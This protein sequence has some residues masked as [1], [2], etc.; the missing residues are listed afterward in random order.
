MENTGP[1]R[2][3]IAD[4]EERFRTTTEA[5]LKKRGFS[6]IVAAGGFQAIEE[7]QKNNFDVVVLDLKM[8]G[9]DG[10]EALRRIKQNKPD[11][12]VIMLTGHGTYETAIAG[13]RRGVFDYLTKPCDIDLLIRKI[14]DAFAR[15]QGLAEKEKRIRDIMVPL[16]EFSTIRED[17]TVAEAV[18]TLAQ[19]FAKA[20][21]TN[22][23]SETVH[24][25]VLVLDHRGR[26]IGVLIFQDLLR[27]L[28]PPSL[29]LRPPSHPGM[30]TIMVQD[31]LKQTVRELMSEVPPVIDTGA[32]LMEAANRLLLLKVPRLL[33][34]ERDNPV[35]V[36]REQDLFFEMVSILRQ[37]R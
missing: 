9:I 28:Q 17:R 12:E 27:A 35:G 1:I 31:I 19:S 22:T 33:V 11:V 30:F 3:L 21:I 7:N 18:E 13:L 10:N 20:M 4:D 16:S 14:Q 34:M 5:I 8:P 2:V 29:R 24:R 6:V 36:V 15:K 25:S 32:D 26:V 37:Q 23:L